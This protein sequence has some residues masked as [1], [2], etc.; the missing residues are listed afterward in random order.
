MVTPS[1]IAEIVRI[2]VARCAPEKVILFGSYALGT[3]QEG[4]DLDLA[5]VKKTDLPTFK[6]PIEFQKALREGGRRWLFPMD[7]LV[8]TPEEMEAW[9]TNPYSLV[10]E[11]SKTGKTLYES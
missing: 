7:I 3:A 8:Y 9:K 1:Q 5:I 2:L 6:R 11:I 4:S 10:H